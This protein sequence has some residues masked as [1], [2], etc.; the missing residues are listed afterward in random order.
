VIPWK[1]ISRACRHRY[2]LRDRRDAIKN[3]SGYD[4][5]AEILL[6]SILDHSWQA[7]EIT[8]YA[9]KPRPEWSTRSLTNISSA[10]HG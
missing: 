3:W 7:H 1:A 2:R 10:A 4:G 5:A 6:L 8:V 9:T